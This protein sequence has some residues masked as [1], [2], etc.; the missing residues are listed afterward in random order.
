M[1]GSTGRDSCEPREDKPGLGLVGIELNLTPGWSLDRKL[2]K[3]AP[4][5]NGGR[6]GASSSGRAD[7][8]IELLLILGPGLG[9]SAPPSP[10]GSAI[11][12]G[13]GVASTG[14]FSGAGPGGVVVDCLNELRTRSVVMYTMRSS[15][16]PISDGIVWRGTSTCGRARRLS[17]GVL[18]PSVV[19]AAG[20]GA[21][22]EG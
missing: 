6:A 3:A 12:P 5:P 21:F 14:I 17:V 11:S 2:R 13:L 15:G 1:S 4:G 18:V 9:L 10:I 7:P 19:A 20:G 22:N 16:E 8:I